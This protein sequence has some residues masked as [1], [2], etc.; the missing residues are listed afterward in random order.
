[1][2]LSP[3]HAGVVEEFLSDLRFAVAN[4][5]EDRGVKARYSDVQ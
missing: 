4:A 2:M 1:M 3:A 5:G